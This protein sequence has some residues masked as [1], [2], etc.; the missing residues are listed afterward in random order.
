MDLPN[1][2]GLRYPTLEDL[3]VYTEQ[4]GAVVVWSRTR[5]AAF[6]PGTREEAPAIYLP[7]NADPLE[8]AWLLAHELGHLFHHAGP[9]QIKWRRNEAEANRWA[10]CALIPEERIQAYRNATIDAFVGALSAHFEDLPL[11]DCPARRLAGKI[12]RIRLNAISAILET[13]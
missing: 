11:T 8:K 9:N 5:Q 4:L 3:E 6:S 1:W 13:T 10:A 2:Y 7:R 12:A